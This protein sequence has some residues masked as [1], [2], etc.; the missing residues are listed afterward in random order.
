MPGSSSFRWLVVRNTKSF[1]AGNGAVLAL[2]DDIGRSSDVPFD[3]ML[4]AF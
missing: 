4:E 1:V 3:F 2:L